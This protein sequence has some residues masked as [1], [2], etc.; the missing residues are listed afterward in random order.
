[1]ESSVNLSEMSREELESLLQSVELELE[2]RAFEDHL[3][4]EVQSHLQKQAWIES[5]HTTQR[6]RG[7]RY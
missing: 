5:H 6:R 7:R 2:A 4:R 3:K 1:M